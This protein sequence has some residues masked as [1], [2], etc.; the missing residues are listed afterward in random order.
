MIVK[1]YF[2]TVNSVC[3]SEN[4]MS[5]NIEEDS[6]AAAA[7][8]SGATARR[9]NY[10]RP[11]RV[12]SSDD[13][14]DVDENHSPSPKRTRVDLSDSRLDFLQKQVSELKYLLTR[15]YTE[16][17][18]TANTADSRSQREHDTVSISSALIESAPPSF[19][20]EAPNTVTADSMKRTS[21]PK[22]RYIKNL[23]H[24]DSSEWSN[25]RYAD[26]Q[27]KYL[28][29]PAFT[30]L[31]LN[32]ELLPFENKPYFLRS[33]DQTFGALTSML[34][35]QREALQESLKTLLTWSSHE[36]TKLTSASLRTKVQELFAN[37]CKFKEISKDIMQ[38][39]CGR[40]ANIIEQRRDHAL[41]GVKDKF[42]KTALRR[43]PPSCEHLFQSREFSEAVTKMGG[44]QK[45]FKR[46]YLPAE[47]SQATP[48]RSSDPAVPF[49]AYPPPPKHQPTP[50][51]A[52]GK[53]IAGK[54][55]YATAK[56]KSSRRPNEDQNR[57][58]Q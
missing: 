34:L 37:D 6:P 44:E 39:T 12:Y 10:K 57:R 21:D 17:P 7:G 41:S 50:V 13:D 49:R 54:R 45:V 40:R 8:T 46:P 1:L 58:R 24:L 36:E 28:S 32:D 30:H 31:G 25:V 56:N 14:G 26:V 2:S 9:I 15:N 51:A 38:V 47:G 22:L 43:I 11:R 29:T 27:K 3:E 33:L 52:K 18:Q 20:W 19:D 55:P 48:K 5:E 42:H 16:L 4:K 23:Q 35:A 53:N